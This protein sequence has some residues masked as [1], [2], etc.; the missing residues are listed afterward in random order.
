MVYHTLIGEHGKIHPSAVING[1]RTVAPKDV[2]YCTNFNF[3]A[4]HVKFMEWYG[5]WLQEHGVEYEMIRFSRGWGWE[6]IRD[7]LQY[8]KED[9]GCGRPLDKNVS[10]PMNGDT[11]YN[12]GEGD[13]VKRLKLDGSNIPL[14]PI[15]PFDKKGLEE[16]KKYLNLNSYEDVEEYL[17][18]G[19]FEAIKIINPKELPY[20]SY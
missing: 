19:D 4:S 15:Y 14:Y 6:P 11:F 7:L 3:Y 13:I 18:C 8:A 1:Y 20:Q 5:S 2:S 16:I 9:V 12:W 10:T 17:R